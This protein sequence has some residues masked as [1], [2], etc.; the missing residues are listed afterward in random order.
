MLICRL[1]RPICIWYA[2]N[3]ERFDVLDITNDRLIG[4]T[5]SDLVS[6]FELAL[7]SEDFTIQMD[8]EL[9]EIDELL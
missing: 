8:D 6:E 4:C 2:M 7:R 9:I 3:T 1:Y 5:D